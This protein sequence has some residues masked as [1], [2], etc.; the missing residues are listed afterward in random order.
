MTILP[1][2]LLDKEQEEKPGPSSSEAGRYAPPSPPSPGSWS[3]SSSSSQRD[4]PYL[5]ESWEVE[6]RDGGRRRRR[7]QVAR[8]APR[9][10][11]DNNRERKNSDDE[12]D[13]A[14]AYDYHVSN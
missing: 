2:I 4:K 9:S 10:P 11:V 1:K 8:A 3:G 14:S 6:R 12:Y 13:A 7:V 5:S